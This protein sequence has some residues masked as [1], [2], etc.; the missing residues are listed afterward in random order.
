LRWQGRTESDGVPYGNAG[1]E[2]A[3]RRKLRGNN[4]AE[5]V[6]PSGA[7]S[8]TRQA[9]TVAQAAK[10]KRRVSLDVL[11]ACW[12]LTLNGLRRSEVLGLRWSDIDL[13]AGTLTV[14]RGRVIVPGGT[15]EGKTKTRR[16]K[17][18]LPLSA[19]PELMAALRALRKAQLAAFGAEHVRTGYLAVDE[20][21]E[22]IHPA[23]YS[24]AWNAHVEAALGD[25][26][27]SFTLHSA[28][29]ASV[30]A[31]RDAGVP[32][33]VVAAWHGHDEA[34]MRATYTHAHEE[35]LAVAGE[36]LAMAYGAGS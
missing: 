34:V 32:D 24:A 22:P 21:G 31:M 4:P 17:R 30:T 23:D 10:I 3:Q 18:T 11:F 25:E 12:L 26:V 27:D 19:I 35:A 8:K 1:P 15:A 29:H 28:R 5:F 20:H 36:A 33:H 16:G 14:Q 7:E 6:E 2:E 9:F 13:Q